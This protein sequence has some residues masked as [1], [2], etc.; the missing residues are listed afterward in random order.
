M[1]ALKID[2]DGTMQPVGITG[3]TIE[4]QNDSIY[5]HLGGYFDTVRLSDDAIMLVDDE[6]LLKCLPMNPAAMMISGY[7]MLVGAALIVGLMPTDDGDVFTDCPQ[8]FIRFAESIQQE[9]GKLNA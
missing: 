8:R 9:G 4:Q 7:P 1:K 6:G 5:E 3:D 2:T